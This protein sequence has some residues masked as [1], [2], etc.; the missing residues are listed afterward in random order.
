[1][2]KLT[3][4][5]AVL[6]LI[7]GCVAAVASEKPEGARRAADR[8]G[9]EGT[10]TPK[11][12]KAGPTIEDE[13]WR[14]PAD[15]SRF[16]VFVLY[17]QSNMAGGIKERFGGTL[18]EEEKTPVPHVLQV[19]FHTK[20][21]RDAGWF[22]AVH[23]LHIIPGR[24]RSF[25]LGL[26]F[27]K[28]YLKRN[29]GVTV[30]LLPCA[31]GGKRMDLLKAGSGLC[32]AVVAKC[33]F[34]QETGTIKGVLWHQGESDAF[35]EDRCAVYEERL[36]EMI[37]A[38]RR[39]IGEPDLPFI[40]GEISV[41]NYPKDNPVQAANRALPQKVKNTGWVRTDDLTFCDGPNKNVHFD[42]KSLVKM[43]HRYCDE[44][45]RIAGETKEKPS[46]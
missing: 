7:A 30:G 22:P 17:G 25:G 46:E 26:P 3:M 18:T 31:Y 40:S 33:R 11:A 10:G 29:P 28:E 8:E 27:A 6:G 39:D 32:N 16:H 2:K 45:M 35:N 38:L 5:P 23:P 15:K 4:I 24:P 41:R 44:L 19:R 34:A 9:S 21:F 14:I 37:A 13:G 36:H 43:A 1:L 20:R 12:T 42:R